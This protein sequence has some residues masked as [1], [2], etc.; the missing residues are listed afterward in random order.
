MDLIILTKFIHFSTL[1]NSDFYDITDEILD[2]FPNAKLDTYYI[3]PVLKRESTDIS[4]RSRGCL[5][6]T[7]Y[8]RLQA[9]RRMCGE[10]KQR[11]NPNDSP[12]I[13][14][15][16]G[17]TSFNIFNINCL[18]QLMLIYIIIILIFSADDMKQSLSWLEHNQINQDFDD[19]KKHWRKIAKTRHSKLLKT[20]GTVSDYIRKYPLLKDTKY[21]PTLIDIDFEELYDRTATDFYL[22]WSK[23][24]E[25]LIT[26]TNHRKYPKVVEDLKGKLL[27]EDNVCRILNN[28]SSLLFSLIVCNIF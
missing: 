18:L 7:F 28:S 21:G 8:N 3:P 1:K 13:D 6:D 14:E 23:I 24:I 20:T 15:P 27:E 12:K 16:L 17:K 4:R 2:I 22:N 9:Y 5:P 25:K 10:S 26:I 11:K 19:I